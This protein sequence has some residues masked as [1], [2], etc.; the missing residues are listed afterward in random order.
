MQIV[1]P[2]RAHLKAY[3]EALETGW[4]PNNLRPEVAQEHLSAIER[5]PDAFLGQMEDRDAQAGP[6]K[7]PDGS[8]VERLP[9]I[10][11][12]I[13]DN[14]FCGSIALRWRP[15]TNDL[16]ATCLGHIGYAV[17]PWR[18]GEGHASAA[19]RA[20]F[21][22]ARNVGLTRLTITTDPENLAS[23][24][25]IEKSGGH[26]VRQNKRPAQMGGGEDMV[27]HIELY[28]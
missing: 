5:D 10:R 22:E 15:G 27:F 3:C 20:M 4:S 16:P 21:P 19:L 11:R 8:L 18:Q 1:R 14:G 24:R 23:R 6:V 12:W 7:L 9:S 13:W 17:V 25:V 28:E 2:S 26:F